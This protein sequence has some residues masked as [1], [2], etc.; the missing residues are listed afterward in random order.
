MISKAINTVVPDFIIR[1]ATKEDLP[2]ILSFIQ[3]LAEY[4]K[5][6]SEVSTTEKDLEQTLFCENPV[7]EVIIGELNNQPVAFAIFFRNYSTFLGKPGLYLE[8]LYVKPEARSKGLG[9]V[10]ISYIAKIAVERSYG[11]FE[12]SVLDWNEPAIN[13]YKKL[14]AIAMSDWTVQ[15][16]TGTNLLK[17]ANEFGNFK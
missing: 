10:M 13:F 1:F 17:L 6:S 15:R 2:L 7:A 3:E 16:L 12:W 5:L 14:G 9:K 8:D 4:E 11:R